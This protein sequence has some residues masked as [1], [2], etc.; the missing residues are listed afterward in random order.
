[1]LFNMAQ[2]YMESCFSHMA[3]QDCYRHGCIDT[4]YKLYNNRLV[5]LISGNLSQN[6]YT[7]DVGVPIV[8]VFLDL[9]KPILVNMAHDK[10]ILACLES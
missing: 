10:T 9:N 4:E 3:C 7:L 6:S 5:S 8:K 1:M 2:T